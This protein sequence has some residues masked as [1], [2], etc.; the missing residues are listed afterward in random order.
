[1]GREYL[2]VLFSL[3][4]VLPLHFGIVNGEINIK[5]HEESRNFSLWFN[6]FRSA[7]CEPE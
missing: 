4:Q 5:E 2:D 3:I 7:V 1:M 6:L